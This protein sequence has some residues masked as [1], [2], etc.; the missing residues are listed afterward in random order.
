MITQ[1][2]LT[3][4]LLGITNT[5]FTAIVFI[6]VYGIAIGNH[7]I[8]WVNS[9]D[10]SV[11]KSLASLGEQGPVVSITVLFSAIIFAIVCYRQ[12]LLFPLLPFLYGLGSVC[13]SLLPIVTTDVEAT[14]HFI[15][16][17]AF[18]VLFITGM[19]LVTRQYIYQQKTVR[20][21]MYALIWIAMAGVL[22]SI[23]AVIYALFIGETS[24]VETKWFTC[25]EFIMGAV[26][27]AWMVVI[28]V[29]GAKLTNDYKNEFKY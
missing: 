7:S 24:D 15:L 3:T 10:V 17:T 20:F 6:S 9:T 28:A 4:L 29:P 14:C 8:N 26:F 23:T 12:N 18:I 19:V 22:C 21:T 27:I 11:S 25:G 5:V 1:E 16:A 2:E 13:F